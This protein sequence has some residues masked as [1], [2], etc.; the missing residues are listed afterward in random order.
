M[1]AFTFRKL[2]HVKLTYI[3]SKY[4]EKRDGNA[5][6]V[7]V[8]VRPKSRFK[9]HE[10]SPII[11]P[12]TNR[13]RILDALYHVVMYPNK[14][15]VLFR[16]KDGVDANNG[17]HSITAYYYVL[18]KPQGR[19]TSIVIYVPDELYKA[20]RKMLMKMNGKQ[21]GDQYKQQN[22]RPKTSD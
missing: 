7:K 20:L 2:L 22:K 21:G 14:A 3:Y 19:L 5:S 13:Q 10:G 15:S 8:R 4:E 1:S 16:L 9:P 6:I 12:I 17:K 11:I 18:S